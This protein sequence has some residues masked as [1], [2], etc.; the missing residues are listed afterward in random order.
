MVSMANVSNCVLN[1]KSEFLTNKPRSLDIFGSVKTLSRLFKMS[2]RVRHVKKCNKT[3]KR[4][5]PGNF[6]RKDMTPPPPGPQGFLQKY[7]IPRPLD[8]QPMCIYWLRIS[9]RTGL[10]TIVVVFSINF[11]SFLQ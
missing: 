9:R 8:F 2:P 1:P 5:T 11:L 10:Q 7:E 4:G 6:L 3:Q